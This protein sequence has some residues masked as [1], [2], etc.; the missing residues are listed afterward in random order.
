MLDQLNAAPFNLTADDIAWVKKTRDSLSTEDK[1]AQVF[2]SMSLRDDPA[3]IKDIVRRKP[4]GVLRYMGP[5][6]AAAWKAT[7]IAVE[8]SEIPLLI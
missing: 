2:C 5:D 7:R 1:I 3:A 4:G 8:S 6:L